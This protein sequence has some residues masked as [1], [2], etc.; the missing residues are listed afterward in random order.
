MLRASSQNLNW[1]RHSFI[2][3]LDDFS[4]FLLSLGW[5][6]VKSL[7]FIDFVLK[8]FHDVFPYINLTKNIP[9]K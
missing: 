1:T 5:Q 3:I 7:Q 8:E 2:E 6:F 4:P 9:I